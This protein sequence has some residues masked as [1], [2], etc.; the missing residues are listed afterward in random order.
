M[1][2]RLNTPRE[3]PRSGRTALR[4]AETFVGMNIQTGVKSPP[5]LLEYL[6][7]EFPGD[8]GYREKG[9]LWGKRCA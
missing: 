3:M 4:A 6:S 9:T 8:A 1:S 5:G 7:D 2:S